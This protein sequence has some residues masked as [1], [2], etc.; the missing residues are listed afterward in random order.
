MNRIAMGMFGC[1]LLLSGCSPK[2]SA[3]AVELPW[4]TDLAAA[5]AQAQSENKMILL[6]FTGSDWCPPCKALHKTV[7]T[8]DEFADF[9]K[10]NLVLVEVDFPHSKPQSEELKKA[11]QNLSERFA[12]EG[13][14][15][16]IVLDASG[17]QLS[18]DVGYDGAKPK[19]FIAKIEALK[20][21]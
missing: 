18:K 17:K 5:Q 21:K 16:V 12:I 3:P 4:L 19:E 1:L 8:S 13:Y 20:K 9:A 15:T 14:P 11:N 2:E 6:D 10:N 7:L